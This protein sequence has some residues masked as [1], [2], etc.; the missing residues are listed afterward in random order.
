MDCLEASC[1]NQRYLCFVGGC[2]MRNKE[3]ARE[4]MNKYRFCKILERMKNERIKCYKEDCDKILETL[5]HKD[6]NHANNR[7]SNLVPVCQEHH[8]AIPHQSDISTPEVPNFASFKAQKAVICPK[9]INDVL[10][11]CNTGRI[12]NLTLRK[13]IGYKNKI[14]IIEGSRHLVE[15]LNSLGFTEVVN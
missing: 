3:R 1:V 6:E 13:S 9:T 14:H 10:Q 7:L 15:L 12:Y 8:L 4:Y 11:N 2:L 5:H